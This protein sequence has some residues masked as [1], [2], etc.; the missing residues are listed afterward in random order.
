MRL[1]FEQRE[2]IERE[3]QRLTEDALEM[4][5]KVQRLQRVLDRDIDTHMR[6]LERRP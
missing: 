1:T 5:R 6:E 4:E 3:I 2:A